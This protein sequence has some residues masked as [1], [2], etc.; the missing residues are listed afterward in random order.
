MY[1]YAK[2]ANVSPQLPVMG[3]FPGPNS[4]LVMDNAHVHHGGRIPKL[5]AAAT[6]LLIYLPPYSPD[7]NPIKKFFLVL[8]SQLKSYQILTGTNEDPQITKDFLPRMVT[9]QLMSGLFRGSGYSS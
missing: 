3:D 4:F 9:P 8:K 2:K 1:C 5:C 7:F 6:V